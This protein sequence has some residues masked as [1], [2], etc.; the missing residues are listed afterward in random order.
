MQLLRTRRGIMSNGRVGSL[1]AHYAVLTLL[2]LPVLVT[3]QSQNAELTGSISDPSG[4]LVPG[5]Q[6]TLTNVATGERRATVTNEAGLYTIPLLQPGKYEITVRKEGF[7]SLTRGDVELHV[8]QTARAD[9]TLEVGALAESVQVTG[10]VAALQAESS[11]LGHVIEN[12][13]V[14]EL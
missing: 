9:F 13:Q 3:A 1:H 2:F 12:K 11:D 5:V 14:L 10:A 6:V 4:G 8:N 7:R